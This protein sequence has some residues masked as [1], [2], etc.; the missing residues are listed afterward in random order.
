M[1]KKTKGAWLVA[2]SRNLDGTS[3]ISGQL[4]NISYAG[5]LGR[6]YNLLRCNIANNPTPVVSKQTVETICRLNGI[7]RA[8]RE[9]GLDILSAK[10]RIDVTSNSIVVLG[11]TS[12]TV[13]EATTDIFTDLGPATEE[14]AVLTLSEK[15]AAK[16]IDRTTATEFIGDAHR[17]PK[18]DTENLIDLCK[19]TNIIDE[20]S[21]GTHAI[22]FNS[23][24]FRDGRY[25]KKAYAV[26][27]SLSPDEQRRLNE[28]QEQLTQNG[29]LLADDVQQVLGE[30]LYRRLIGVGLFDI[31]EVSNSS[32]IV[33]FLTSPNDFQ[34]FRQPFVEDP[35]DDAKALLASLMYGRFRSDEYRGRI[36]YPEALLR[37]LIRGQEVGGESGV[38]AI[39]EDYQELERRR[40]VQVTRTQRSATRFTFRL[41]KREVGELALG[42]L[43][44]ENIAQ[45]AVLIDRGPATNFRGPHA[46]RTEIRNENTDLERR[47][48]LDSLDSLRTGELV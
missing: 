4:E 45:E 15:V 6:F 5:R 18:Q 8:T 17:L 35:L 33:D 42:V 41:L 37:K 46:I 21:K 28:I 36:I 19:S 12:T 23:N 44:G 13:L 3:I 40:V 30:S 48:I 11:A 16:P 2:Q 38:R 47:C 34:K 22:L 10:G 25:A 24:T 27:Q 26:L 1:D 20:E 31:S 43:Q 29:A 9:R 39:G 14:E 7:D 32:E